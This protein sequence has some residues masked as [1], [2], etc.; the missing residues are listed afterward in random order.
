MRYI[1]STRKNSQNDWIAKLIAVAKVERKRTESK[2][3]MSFLRT[4]NVCCNSA[5][6]HLSRHMD[7]VLAHDSNHQTMWTR[8]RTNEANGE[9]SCQV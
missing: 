8:I 4:D 2:K 7:F 5:H 3:T 9:A 1:E 6:R